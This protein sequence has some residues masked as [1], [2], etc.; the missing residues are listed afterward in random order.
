[1]LAS[2]NSPHTNIE[3]KASAG[4]TGKVVSRSTGPHL[5]HLC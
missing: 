2:V 4:R 1:L 3:N 5:H